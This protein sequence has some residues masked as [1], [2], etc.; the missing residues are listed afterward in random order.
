MSDKEKVAESVT[1][2]QR[3]MKGGKNN[4]DGMAVALA[5]VAAWASVQYGVPVEVVGSVA[6]AVGSWARGLRESLFN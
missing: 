6:A 4:A 5:G 2:F 1:A 3:A